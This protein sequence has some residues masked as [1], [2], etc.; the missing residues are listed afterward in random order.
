[1]SLSVGSYV[2]GRGVE[3][4]DFRDEIYQTAAMFWVLGAFCA[5]VIWGGVKLGGHSRTP[6]HS[7]GGTIAPDRPFSPHPLYHD[8]F[9]D[10]E[11]PPIFAMFMMDQSRNEGGTIEGEEEENPTPDKRSDD[12]PCSRSDSCSNSKDHKDDGASSSIVGAPARSYV[13]SEPKSLH[14]RSMVSGISKV[15]FASKTSRHSRPYFFGYTGP[16][17]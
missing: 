14:A 17:S 5:S 9:G 2:V 13:S 12:V 4:A 16:G 11:S 15:S 7:S 1:M 8:A 6:Y 3:N 10:N